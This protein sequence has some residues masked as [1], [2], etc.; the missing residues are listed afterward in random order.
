M[1]IFVTFDEVTFILNEGYIWNC[2]LFCN[3]RVLDSLFDRNHDNV[4]LFLKHKQKCKQSVGLAFKSLKKS[5]I[6]CS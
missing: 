4:E 1:R 2:C 5:I 3:F 6:L